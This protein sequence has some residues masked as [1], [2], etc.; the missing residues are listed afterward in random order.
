MKSLLLS[1]LLLVGLC[2]ICLGQTDD[3]GCNLYASQKDSDCDGESTCATATNCPTVSFK[4]VC[5]DTYWIKAWTDCG[6]THCAHCASCV[7]IYTDPP[8]ATPVY[9]L[10][11]EEECDETEC[12]QVVTT[13]LTAGNYLLKICLVPCNEVDAETCC[14][15]APCVAW[16]EISKYSLSCE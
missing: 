13:T 11:T 15:G 2:S 12:C 1:G 3:P 10:S 4:V 5:N 9:F 14:G 8:G 16:G 6:L 7:S